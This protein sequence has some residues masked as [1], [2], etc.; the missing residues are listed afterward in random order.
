MTQTFGLMALTQYFEELKYSG[1]GFHCSSN[2]IKFDLQ[3][4]TIHIILKQIYTNYAQMEILTSIFINVFIIFHEMYNGNII[5]LR[6][7]KFSSISA[8]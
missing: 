6:Y 8:S 2:E 7:V 4:E 3:I 1:Q 5:S